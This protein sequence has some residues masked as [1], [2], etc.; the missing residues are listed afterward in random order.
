M[1]EP[2]REIRPDAT[3]C[4]PRSGGGWSSR[5]GPRT[6]RPVPELHEVDVPDELRRARSRRRCRATRRSAPPRSPRSGPCSA[7]TA[8]A[9]PEGIRQAA[10][11]MG[12]TP[13]YLE[14]LATFY[15]LFRTTP[16]G[17]HQ[18]LVCHNIS[19]WMRGAD[20]LLQRLLRGR[21]RRCPRGRPRRRQLGRR[22]GLRRGLRV[23]GRLRHRADGLDRRALL[24]AAGAPV[25]RG[26]RSSSFAPAPRSCRTRRSPSARGRRPEPDPDP[27]RS[28]GAGG[29]DRPETRMLFRHIDEPGLA[30]IDT[31]RRLGGYRSLERAVQA[32]WSPRSCS[33]MLEESGL[34]GR[35]GAGFSMGKK[36]SFLPR[37][38]M[39]EV[40]VLQRRRVR[41]GRVQGPRADAEEPAPADRGDRDRGARRRR[42]LGVRLH[43]GRV[44]GGG[45]HPRARG[46]RGLRGRLPGREHPRHRLTG[47]SWSSTAAPGAYI[48]GEETALLDSLE[49][50]RGNPRLKPPFPAIQGL[51]GGPT[52]INNVETLSNVPHI[53]A[54]GAEWFKGLRHRAVARAP[55]SSRSRAACSGPATT[56]SSSGS[57]PGS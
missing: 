19:C 53:V 7:T 48:C 18:V 24:R 35:G 6:P 50:K 12:V 32:T 54:N 47:S 2:R 1:S 8:G 36:A 42:R 51:Y 46:R 40:P 38:E 15:D 11:V 3:R 41:A 23:P 25:T 39:D 28:G 5:C 56:R 21:R 13:G 43:P 57:R 14:S 4:P 17:R 20:D 29:S 34:R 30:S 31:Y 45:R 33:A 44:R 16:V 37:G 26:P 49:G 10:A 27:R 9:R 55:R 52:L 22:R